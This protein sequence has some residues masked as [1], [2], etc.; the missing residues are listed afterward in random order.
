MEGMGTLVE[1]EE[2][3]RYT[4]SVID[5][6]KWIDVTF[7]QKVKFE[8]LDIQRDCFPIYVTITIY[9]TIAD[10]ITAIPSFRF[11]LLI[12]GISLFRF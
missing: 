9:A 11:V 3:V 4:I 10:V 5:D 6:T 8:T 2:M 7:I 12:F 1:M